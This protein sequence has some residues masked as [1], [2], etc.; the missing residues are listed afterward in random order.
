MSDDSERTLDPTAKRRADFRK[1]GRFAQARDA[2]AVT[3]IGA[4]VGVLMSMRETISAAVVRLV[5]TCLGAVAD[6]HNANYGS[7]GQLAL[8]VLLTLV[9]PPIVVAGIAGLVVGFAQAGIGLHTENLGFKFERLDPIGKLRELFSPG[10]ATKELVLVLVKVALIG[11]VAYEA[12]RAELPLVLSSARQDVPDAAR[13]LGAAIARLTVKTAV[14]M[15]IVAAIDYAQSRFRI[16]REMKMTLREVK[17]EA[18]SED[19][20]PKVKARMRARARALARRR[21]MSDVSQASLV[22]CNPTHIAVA[23]RYDATDAA[24]VVVAKGHDDVALAIRKRA[25]EHGIPIIE[26]RPLARALDRDVPLGKAVKAEHFVAVARVLAF[27]YRL[28]GKRRAPRG[29]GAER[30]RSK[31][32]PRA[33]LA[34]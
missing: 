30:G 13:E 23:L 9:V 17:D 32:P 22:V 28:G 34:R 7:I 4:T 29:R 18:R 8:G 5:T 10:R 20:D 11:A 26:N 25:R 19:G 16:E 2:G 12:T 31:T 14:A 27:V 3:V 15:V 6:P 21:M 33:Q 1:Q 24:P